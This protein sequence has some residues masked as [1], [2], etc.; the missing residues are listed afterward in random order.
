MQVRRFTKEELGTKVLFP[1][2]QLEGLNCKD[3]DQMPMRQDFTI[4]TIHNIPG[5]G[6]VK[7]I[8]QTTDPHMQFQLITA[9]N[10]AQFDDYLGTLLGMHDLPSY[11][12][13][14]TDFMVLFQGSKDGQEIN[15]QNHSEVYKA[16]CHAQDQAARWWHLYGK[17]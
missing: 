7:I 3:A 9:D 11:I 1:R 2:T 12:A 14:R 5:V 13:G 6:E 4:E 8:V 15:Q 17:N 16:I 10:E